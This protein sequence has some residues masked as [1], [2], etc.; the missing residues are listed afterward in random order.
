MSSVIGY[1]LYYPEIKFPIEDPRILLSYRYASIF[2]LSI[3][4]ENKSVFNFNN[5]YYYPTDDDSAISFTYIYA[6]PSQVNFETNTMS[7]SGNMK[8]LYKWI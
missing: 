6:S 1:W 4:P 7:G 5:G 3:E 8:N 2:D